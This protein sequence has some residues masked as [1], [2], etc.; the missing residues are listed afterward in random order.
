MDSSKKPNRVFKYPLIF[1]ISKSR[2]FGG[3]HHNGCRH[4][5]TLAD[6]VR[7]GH[8]RCRHDAVCRA[9]AVEIHRTEPS[10]VTLALSFLLVIAMTLIAEGFGTHVPKGYVYAAMSFAGFVEGLN[11]LSRRLKTSRE[12]DSTARTHATHLH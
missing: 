3:P 7:R 8:L 4:D 11:F 9:T 2:V 5:G 12:R 6:H 1:P 10:V